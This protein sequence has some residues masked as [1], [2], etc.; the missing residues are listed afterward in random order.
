MPSFDVHDTLPADAAAVVDH[1]LGEFND[2]A[3]PL[4]LVAPRAAFAREGDTLIGGAVGRTWGTGCE[5]QQ[6]W[7][8]PAWRRRGIAREIVQRFEA[9][10]LERGCTSFYLYTF[11][12]QARPFYEA[13]GYRVAYT[14]AGYPDRIEQY[15]MVKK[16]GAASAPAATPP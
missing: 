5:L 15:L 1:G 11:S 12:F 16:A 9:R 3:A 4:D 8:H 7:V 13:L 2:A 10:A 6:L 14:L